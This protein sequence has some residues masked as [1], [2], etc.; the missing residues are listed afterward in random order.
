MS[1]EGRKKKTESEKEHKELIPSKMTKLKK[2]HYVCIYE[3]KAQHM[4]AYSGGMPGQHLQKSLM[5]HD[6]AQPLRNKAILKKKK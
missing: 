5:C 3:L 2:T 6:K 4:N 1:E